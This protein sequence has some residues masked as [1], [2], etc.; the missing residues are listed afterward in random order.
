MKSNREKEIREMLAQI[1]SK[2]N[3][4]LQEAE[5]EF[6]VKKNGLDKNRSKVLM[7]RLLAECFSSI[8]GD[9]YWLRG[10]QKGILYISQYLVKKFCIYSGLAIWILTLVILVTEYILHVSPVGDISFCCP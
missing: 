4:R 10:I 2:Y 9:H 1:N 5:T 8:C 7:N 6:S 3:L